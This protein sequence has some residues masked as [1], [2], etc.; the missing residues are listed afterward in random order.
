MSRLEFLDVLEGLLPSIHALGAQFRTELSE[1]SRR[2]GFIREVRGF[3]LMIG[4]E[5]DVPGKQI[6]LDAMQEGLLIN[7]THDTVLRFLP[8]YIIT[9]KEIDRA[10]KILTKVLKRVQ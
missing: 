7:C 3:G 9:A 10:V 6:V 2:F 8:P 4:M 1:L 5:L